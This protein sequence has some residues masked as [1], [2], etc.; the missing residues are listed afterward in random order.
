MFLKI[1]RLLEINPSA[2]SEELSLGGT[3]RR[4]VL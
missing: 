2:R 1:S 3:V 4:V